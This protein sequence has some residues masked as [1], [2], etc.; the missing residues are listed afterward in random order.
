MAVPQFL[1]Q[2]LFRIAII[3]ELHQFFCLFHFFGTMYYL[4]S[5]YK[6]DAHFAGTS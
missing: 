4:F 5:K 6:E 2:D 1:G 3:Q